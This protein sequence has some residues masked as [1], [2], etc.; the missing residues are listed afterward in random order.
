MHLSTTEP[1]PL[2]VVGLGGSL[3]HHSTSLAALDVALDVV[4]SEGVAIERLALS[5]L[6]IPLYR[7]GL[8]PTTDVLRLVDAVARADALIWSAPLYH[9]SISGAFKNAPD[10][11]QLLAERQPPYLSGK[12]VGL[13]AAAGGVQALQAVNSMEFVV[14]ALRGWTIPLVVPISHARRQLM[15][16]EATGADARR[17][18]EALA[19][20]VIRAAAQLGRAYS[21]QRSTAEQRVA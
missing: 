13:I 14:R 11:L 20:E 6:D 4:R 7:T 18:L 16:G 9:G 19:H 15:P 5:E 12:P 21:D 3:E 1:S 10:W 8:E 17:Q 2:L